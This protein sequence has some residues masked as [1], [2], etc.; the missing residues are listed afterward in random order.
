[1]CAICLLLISPPPAGLGA[2]AIRQFSRVGNPW[3]DAAQ[4]AIVFAF[5]GFDRARLNP[6]SD[7]L[8]SGLLHSVRDKVIL[9]D[10]SEYFMTRPSPFRPGSTAPGAQ[11]LTGPGSSRRLA[12]QSIGIPTA[13]RP[14]SGSL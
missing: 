12:S 2:G 8:G 14:F 11:R 1:M 5:V 3:N 4:P 7:H 6:G 10:P 9:G 13:S